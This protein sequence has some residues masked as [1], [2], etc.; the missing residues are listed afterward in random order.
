M[1]AEP[2]PSPQVRTLELIERYSRTAVED[3]NR[4]NTVKEL[5]EIV[6]TDAHDTFSP[7]PFAIRTALDYDVAELAADIITRVSIA[8]IP[9]RLQALIGFCNNH[10]T[11]SANNP[12]IR[13][14]V[15][16]TLRD[17][18]NEPFSTGQTAI[19][20]AMY[21]ESRGKSGVLASMLKY[22][23]DP[24]QIIINHDDESITYTPLE[25][26]KQQ[27]KKTQFV[28]A[29]RKPLLEAQNAKWQAVVDI[30]ERHIAGKPPLPATHP[31]A[32]TA[33][34]ATLAR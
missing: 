22:G 17:V 28:A 15:F 14:A 26:A 5:I 2:P 4:E 21:A 9:D 7:I 6:G 27:I 1:T 24:Q 34:D 16:A 30:L 11:D 25:W 20:P 13:D 33:G 10:M 8:G 29:A 3:R 19:F 12:E 18:I 31:N 23:A 32:G